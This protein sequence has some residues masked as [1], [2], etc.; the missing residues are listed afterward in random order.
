M[1]T[2]V[3]DP[4]L[5]PAE[6]PDIDRRTRA[7]LRDLN[8]DRTAFWELP[9][10]EPQRV[11]TSLQERTPVDLSG[12][13]IATREITSRGGPLTLYAVRPAGA[14]GILPVFLFLHGAVWI[15]GNFE[16]HQR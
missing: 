4:R 13:T 14:T 10:D 9:G 1:T 5:D 12:V 15:A 8:R 11:M 3:D 2:S 6:D 7:F 16:N